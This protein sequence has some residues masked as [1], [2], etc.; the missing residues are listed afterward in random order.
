MIPNVDRVQVTV[1]WSH[2]EGYE[3]RS[4]IC[5]RPGTAAVE[6]HQLRRVR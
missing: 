3:S 1:Q 6:S 5:E 4:S 2:R